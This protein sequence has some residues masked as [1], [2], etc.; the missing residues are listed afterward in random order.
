VTKKSLA[1]GSPDSLSSGVDSSLVLFNDV[2]QVADRTAAAA[3][4][5]FA[6]LL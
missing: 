3:T 1:A 5:E 6:G 4:A 2:V